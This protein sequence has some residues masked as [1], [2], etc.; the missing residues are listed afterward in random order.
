MSLE[1]SGTTPAVKGVAG[2]VSAPAIT[3]DDA[4]TGISLPAA[5]TIKFSTGGVERLAITNSGITGID[6]ITEVDNWR[7]TTNANNSGLGYITSNWERVDT[8]FEKIGTGLSESSGVFTFPSTGKYFIIYFLSYTSTTTS[9][10]TGGYIRISTDNGGSYTRVTDSFD[11]IQG[12]GG[13]ASVSS[14][15]VLDITETTNTSIKFEVETQNTT[16]IRG[17]SSRNSTGFVCI[18]LGD[19]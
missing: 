19:T 4:N 10:F 8:F 13:Y 11:D 2:S 6:S 7:L 14:F 17:D 1:L 16:T 15:A 9:D 3:G 12:S 5:D 18:R